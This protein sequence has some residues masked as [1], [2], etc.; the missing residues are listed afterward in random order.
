MRSAKSCSYCH[1]RAIAPS[2]EARRM[3][4]CQCCYEE[5]PEREIVRSQ[6]WPINRP[7]KQAQREAELAE[8]MEMFT[9]DEEKDE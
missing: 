4:I 1:N 5:V 7:E 3:N 9:L 8:L 2:G 6:V